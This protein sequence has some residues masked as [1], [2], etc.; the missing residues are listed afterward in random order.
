ME[1]VLASGTTTAIL[2]G[3]TLQGIKSATALPQEIKICQDDPPSGLRGVRSQGYE[4]Q[5]HLAFISPF[6]DIQVIHHSGKF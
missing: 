1:Q 5:A 4:A 2:E 3:E 6:E